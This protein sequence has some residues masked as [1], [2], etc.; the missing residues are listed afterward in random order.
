MFP[1]PKQVQF[2]IDS[3]FCQ[4]KK[5]EPPEEFMSASCSHS[6]GQEA[7]RLIGRFRAEVFDFRLVLVAEVIET[8][9]V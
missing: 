8:Q 7:F 6:D 1:L 4:E 2:T 3:F 5:C 9:T